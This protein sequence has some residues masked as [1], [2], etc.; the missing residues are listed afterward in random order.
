MQDIFFFI[1]LASLALAAV[2]I[3]LADSS[4][5]SWLRGKTE[6]IPHKKLMVP[7]YIVTGALV[8]LVTTGLLLFWPM[9]DYLI[10]NPLFLIKMAFVVA[11]II[12]ALAIDRLMDTATTQSFS[13]LSGTKKTLLLLSGAIS[14][15]SWFGAGIVALIL[16][17]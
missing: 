2:G 16:F 13:S 15:I 4:A 11:L 5:L 12:N 10:G 8:G 1:H 17:Y 3:L 14:T 9:R 6:V 7:H